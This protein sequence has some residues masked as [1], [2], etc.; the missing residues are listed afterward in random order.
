MRLRFLF[1]NNAVS[2]SAKARRKINYFL[3]PTSTPCMHVVKWQEHEC[4]RMRLAKGIWHSGVCDF[5][6]SHRECIPRSFSVSTGGPYVSVVDVRQNSGRNHS[7]LCAVQHW[8]VS[9]VFQ[10]RH[11][12]QS[13]GIR[14][15]HPMLND[16]IALTSAHFDAQLYCVVCS[17][18]IDFRTEFGWKV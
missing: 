6:C 13:F 12:I 16:C 11:I 17:T 14:L 2:V 18:G 4:W 8:T 1:V 9:N 5:F 15:L 10:A 3:P 7:A